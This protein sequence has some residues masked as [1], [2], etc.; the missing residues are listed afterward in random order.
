[1]KFYEILLIFGLILI[2][3][4]LHGSLCFDEKNACTRE[5]CAPLAFSPTYPCCAP[6]ST[7]SVG[8]CY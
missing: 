1:M 2:E 7:D 5:G 8:L 4:Q 3:V 6:Y